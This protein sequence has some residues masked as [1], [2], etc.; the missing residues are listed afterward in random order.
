MVM[1]AGYGL[2]EPAA[3]RP[4]QR[5]CQLEQCDEPGGVLRGSASL[6]NWPG[7][8]NVDHVQHLY[9]SLPLTAV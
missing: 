9:E 8:E 3:G 7:F 5:E 6:A 1:P 2:V 4:A